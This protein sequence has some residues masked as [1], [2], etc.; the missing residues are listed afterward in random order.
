[1]IDRSQ[2]RPAQE[3]LDRITSERL[4][5]HVSQNEGRL[6]AEEGGDL[7][8]EL[9]NVLE[10]PTNGVLNALRRG[11]YEGKLAYRV[12]GCTDPNN[13][14]RVLAVSEALPRE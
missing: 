3:T 5:A 11:H 7:V 8:P 14:V 1:M 10:M 12:S 13:S 4:F 2:P 9:R 6:E